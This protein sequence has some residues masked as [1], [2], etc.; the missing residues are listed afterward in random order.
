M[1]DITYYV[2]VFSDAMNA[3]RPVIL[4]RYRCPAR[5]SPSVVVKKNHLLG[6]CETVYV[7]LPC[8]E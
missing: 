8:N 3:G 2:C 6:L 4:V 1:H 5:E 7:Q